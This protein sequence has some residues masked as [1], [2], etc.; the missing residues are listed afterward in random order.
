[1]T[2]EELEPRM[3]SFNSPV[4]GRAPDC[5]GLGFKREFE[6][7]L[8]IPD[9]TKSLSGGAVKLYGV[10]SDG[11]VMQ[12][13]FK[14][15]AKRYGFDLNAP[16]K[17]LPDE[18]M[19]ILLWGKRRR[20]ALDR[21]SDAQLRGAVHK[22]LARAY[23]DVGASLQRVD[24]RYGQTGIR[25]LYGG[26]GVPDLSR[27]ETQKEVLSVKIGGKNIYELTQMSVEECAAFFENLRLDETKTLIARMVLKEINARLKFLKD[28]GLDYLTLARS[29][30]SL[31]G[32]EA[33]RIRLA[34]QIGSGLVGVLYI[35]TSRA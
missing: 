23:P 10:Q 17:E 12:L 16:V 34:T 6:P 1:M 27:K 14:A 20:A 2:L 15:L 33:Q 28:V 32:G 19:R 11:G 5:T 13:Y 25:K 29:S 31:S 24:K 21:V 35:L 3:F 26:Q 30:G 7:D 4:L 8:V 18:I 22:A 9:K